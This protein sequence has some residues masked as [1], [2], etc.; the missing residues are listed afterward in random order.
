MLEVLSSDFLGAH[1]LN[2]LVGDVDDFKIGFI[3]DG[4]MNKDDALPM[5]GFDGFGSRCTMIVDDVPAMFVAGVG[6]SSVDDVE[7]DDVVGGGWKVRR[8]DAG[9]LLPLGF[10][11][12]ATW[13]H[14]NYL[15]GLSFP[16][17]KPTFF[18]VWAW[19]DWVFMAQQME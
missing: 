5:V 17:F 4:S 19:L 12:W 3:G 16:S 15:M 2:S 8:G 1:R 18:L 13:A 14:K 11:S 6:G 9:L 7:A 10:V